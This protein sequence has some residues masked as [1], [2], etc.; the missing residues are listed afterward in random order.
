MRKIC[1][2]SLIEHQWRLEK[3]R[4]FREDYIL[5]PGV[6]WNCYVA[7]RSPGIKGTEPISEQSFTRYWENYIISKYSHWSY[8]F[9]KFC[10][11]IWTMNTKLYY[12]ILQHDGCQ[13]GRFWIIYLNITSCRKLYCDLD[14]LLGSIFAYFPNLLEKLNI[15]NKSMMIIKCR[16]F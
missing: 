9:S 6:L 7:Q 12:C 14:F 3:C 4:S 13:Q 16:I 1:Q 10:A 2:N 11:N 8:N 5:T 15:L